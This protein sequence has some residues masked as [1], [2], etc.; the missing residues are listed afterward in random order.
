MKIR[1]IRGTNQIGGCITEITTKKAKII[2]DFGE[3]LSDNDQKD[4]IQLEGLTYGKPA[5]DGVFITHSHSDHIG[6][7]D[8]ILPEIKVYVEKYSYKIYEISNS[9][10]YKNTRKQ[11]KIVDFEETVKIKDIRITYFIIDHSAFN[12]AMILIEAEGKRILHTGDFRKNGRKGVLFEKIL[13]KIGQVDYLI[14][15]GTCLSRKAENNKTENELLKELIPVF[16]KYNQVFVLQS[17]TNIDRVVTMYRASIKTKKNFIEDLCTANIALALGEKYEIPNINFETNTP[18]VFEP[19]WQKRKIDYRKY[20]NPLKKRMVNEAVYKDFCML[21]KSNKTTL[22]MIKAFQN[23]GYVN[24]AC[25]IYSMSRYY[26]ENN[27]STASFVDEIKKMGIDFLYFH[28]SGHADIS[29][30]K[31]M[32][33]ITKPKYN[34]IVIHTDNKEKAEEI[35]GNYLSINDWEVIE[36]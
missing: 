8:K 36:I 33:K 25:F 26:L 32:Y 27:E 23:K 13:K 16:K 1:I 24:N 11:I 4:D 15:E 2:I 12:S 34:T 7:I 35:F 21:I 22:R 31:K 3:E 28:T 17:S 29:T 5:Y 9:F 14:T 6:Q 20:Y 30:L 19:L 10:Q 18:F